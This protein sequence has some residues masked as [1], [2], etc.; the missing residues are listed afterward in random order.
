MSIPLDED[1]D[2]L[3]QC[4]RCGE[5]FKVDAED[6]QA[7]DVWE[8]WCPMCGIKSDC[9]LPE[10]ALELAQ[11][12]VLN[13]VMETFGKQLANI[14]KDMPRQSPIRLAVT[15]HFEKA[16]ERELFPDVDA[17]ETVT[18]GFAAVVK[19]LNLC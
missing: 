12:K 7:E 9:F 19:R 10:D 6:Y 5:S 11:A 16:R 18:C 14:G 2:L 4:P 1:G 15:T 8:L 3:L 13:H 17:F